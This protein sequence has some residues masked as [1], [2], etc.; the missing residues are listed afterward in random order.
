MPII[1]NATTLG[2]GVF[3][4]SLQTTTP[5]IIHCAKS[6]LSGLGHPS[7]PPEDVYNQII[8]ILNDGIAAISQDITSLES[9]HNTDVKGLQNQINN[10]VI[11]ASGSG[12]VTAE[13]AQARVGADGTNHGTLKERI[14]VEIN[15][16]NEDLSE[17]E[18]LSYIANR[19]FSQTANYFII[20]VTETEPGY[21]AAASA[22]NIIKDN[23][24]KILKVRVK[25]NTKYTATHQRHFMIF[26]DRDGN[27]LGGA[28][29]KDTDL[30]NYTFETPENTYYACLVVPKGENL[31][32]YMVV[33][34][35][36]MPE[37]YIKGEVLLKNSVN[38]RDAF[39]IY[40]TNG[41]P[42]ITYDIGTYTLIIP[43]ASVYYKGCGIPVTKQTLKVNELAPSSFHAWVIRFD[44]ANNTYIVEL[45]NTNAKSIYPIIGYIYDNRVYILGVE[46]K[47]ITYYNNGKLVIS[48][49]NSAIIGISDS[50][51]VV[52]DSINK[53][54]TIPLGFLI[55]DG[56]SYPRQQNITI[57]VSSATSTDGACKLWVKLSDNSYF[58]TYWNTAPNS[59]SRCIGYIYNNNVV[60]Y[61]VKDSSIKKIT[62]TV[63]FFGDSITAGVHAT[64]P[65]HYY[66]SRWGL[67]YKCLNY[68]VGST[69]YVLTATGSVVSGEGVEGQGHVITAEGNNS[70]IQVMQG[71]SDI[72][73]CVI[74]AGTNDWAANVSIDTFRTKVQETL[75]YAL[76][77]TS[78]GCIF[79]ITPIKRTNYNQNNSV[80]HKLHDY[81][82]VIIEECE[83]RGIAYC[84][85]FDVSLNPM[86][87]QSNAK[88]MGDG[89]HPNNNG[90]KKIARCCFN[91]FLESMCG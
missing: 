38:T 73:R 25:P 51:Q 44:Y 58:A 61:G 49:Y 26:T 90:Q 56:V 24:F 89:I 3:A 17:L 87:K 10:I 7:D 16:L 53:T 34:G 63:L 2:I 28:G 81:S 68:G 79:V 54:L 59:A 74:A 4:D 30:Y 32:A 66:F 18:D 71:V 76:Q 84:D 8:E 37:T 11:E 70:I 64:T 75:D 36:T 20:G 72:E 46:E 1:E 22:N 14:D 45:W 80:G 60:I 12:D 83:S 21:F 42:K 29:Q 67:N 35:E 77:N 15:A 55:A 82:E 13:V 19:A 33:E 9:K 65:Y 31:Y 41:S 27:W 47:H 57:D 91:K 78:T 39:A 5:A 40:N 43:Q 85:G 52:Y 50:F 62:K 69:G 86:N 88:F 48:S 6:V 23:N